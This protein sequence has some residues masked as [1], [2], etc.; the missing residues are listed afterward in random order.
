MRA[1]TVE[2][3]GLSELPVRR[4]PRVRCSLPARAELCGHRV[5]GE[6]R[7]LSECGMLFLGPLMLVGER[8]AVSLGLPDGEARVRGSVRYHHA[9]LEGHACGI[10]FEDDRSTLAEIQRVR[11]YVQ[12]LL[13]GG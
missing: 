6:C 13:I 12:Q 2:E 9:A 3:V 5:R 10:L 7:D 8:V 1:R 4:H 11:A